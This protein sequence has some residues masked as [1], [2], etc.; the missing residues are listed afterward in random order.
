MSTL[1]GGAGFSWGLSALS[2]GFF[3]SCLSVSSAGDSAS[4]RDGSGDFTSFRS[5]TAT[6][7]VGLA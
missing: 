7:C 5:G 6:I 1:A 4:L 2:S 3:S